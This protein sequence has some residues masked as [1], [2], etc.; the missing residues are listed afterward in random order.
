MTTN[1]KLKWII[2]FEISILITTIIWAISY[3][4]LKHI[5]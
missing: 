4:L 2:R 5:Q 1:E 3:E